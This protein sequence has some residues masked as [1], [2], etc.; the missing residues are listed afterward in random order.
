M[1]SRFFGRTCAPPRT[2]KP[3]RNFSRRQRKNEPT[4][5]ALAADSGG[6][7]LLNT[8]DSSNGEWLLEESYR[9]YDVTSCVLGL[10][11]DECSIH[12]KC[13]HGCGAGP[14]F[15]FLWAATD[16]SHASP[17]SLPAVAYFGKVFKN[18]EATLDQLAACAELPP[19]EELVATLSIPWRRL[20]RVFSH[21][22]AVHWS[23]IE[24]MGAKQAVREAVTHSVKVVR[25]YKNALVAEAELEPL[26]GLEEPNTV[27]AGRVL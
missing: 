1:L 14:K 23:T 26:A 2:F 13:I 16:G 10:V 22:I 24:S 3:L 19:N 7:P 4:S 8:G 18:S 21:V 25:L 17:R 12:E 6:F 20:L 9:L 27:I 11:L 5:S 15:E